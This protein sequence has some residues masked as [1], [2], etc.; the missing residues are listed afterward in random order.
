MQTRR[1]YG[2]TFSVQSGCATVS[3]Q[4]MHVSAQ[5]THSTEPLPLSGVC[6]PRDLHSFQIGQDSRRGGVFDCA[7]C[8]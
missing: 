8:P 5:E 1:V 6:L 4:H 2:L 3:D 7:R